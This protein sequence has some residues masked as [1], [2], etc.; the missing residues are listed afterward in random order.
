MAEAKVKPA[1]RVA[2][3]S[4]FRLP[5]RTPRIAEI[6]PLRELLKE[7]KAQEAAT[8]SNSLT[9]DSTPAKQIAGVSQFPTPTRTLDITPANMSTGAVRSRDSKPNTENANSFGDFAKRWAPILRPGQM[10]V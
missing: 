8:V 4:K 3:K 9:E 1:K 6:N 10:S 7:A 2:G 5:E